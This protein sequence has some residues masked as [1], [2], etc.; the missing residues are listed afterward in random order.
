LFLLETL[1]RFLKIIR[2]QTIAQAMIFFGRANFVSYRNGNDVL[3][4]TR[5]FFIRFP[6][7]R[8]NDRRK[9]KEPPEISVKSKR[10]AKSI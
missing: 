4:N 8:K 3:E 5:F 6:E 7:I 1:F 9:R 10:T 2:S